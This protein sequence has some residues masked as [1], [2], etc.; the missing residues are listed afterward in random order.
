[1]AKDGEVIW[2]RRGDV[3]LVDFDPTLGAEIKKTRPVLIVQNDITN[4]WGALTI[5]AAITSHPGQEIYPTQ[6]IVEA[7][8]GGLKTKSVIK[9]EQIRSI[10]K[11]RL[12]HKLGRVNP[13]TLLAVD[14]ALI[15]SLGLILI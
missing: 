7:G 6:V 9:L 8:E 11:Q 14:R 10:D 1:M 3:Y 2:P 5:V 12:K 4:Q 15:I 13:D